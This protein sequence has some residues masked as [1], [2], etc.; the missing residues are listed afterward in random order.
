MFDWGDCPFPFPSRENA[1]K[2]ASNNLIT[3]EKRI[4]QQQLKYCSSS[5][6]EMLHKLLSNNLDNQEAHT[7]LW[8]K[9][10]TKLLNHKLSGNAAETTTITELVRKIFQYQLNSLVKLN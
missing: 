2:L 10:Y 6:A 8:Q 9:C 4:E 1:A 7:T 5:M 3:D